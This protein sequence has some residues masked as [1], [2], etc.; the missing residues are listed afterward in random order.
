MVIINFTYLH[1]RYPFQQTF[2]R[3]WCC[4]TPHDISRKLAINLFFQINVTSNQRPN[5]TMAKFQESYFLSL[6][7]LWKCIYSYSTRR[8]VNLPIWKENSGCCVHSNTLG[9]ALCE[10]ISAVIFKVNYEW[11][12]F[13]QNVAY[14]KG[15]EEKTLSLCQVSFVVWGLCSQ[16]PMPRVLISHCGLGRREGGWKVSLVPLIAFRGNQ[17]H[18][19][20]GCRKTVAWT[21]CFMNTRMYMADY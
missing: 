19:L 2:G 1:T 15:K 13:S 3:V 6:C 18:L 4:I 11:T 14:W 21:P 20:A 10:R 12:S 17:N 7:A 5:Q 8:A 9:E 16:C